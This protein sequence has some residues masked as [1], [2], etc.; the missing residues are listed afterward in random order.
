MKNER[1]ILLLVAGVQFVNVLDFMMVMPLGP[2]F[3]RS[4]GI[5]VSH[6]GVIG[7]SYTAAAS[8]SGLVGALFLDRFDRRPALAVA[9]I[10]LAAGTIL[11]GLAHGIT[12]L[13]AARVVAGAFGGPATSLS[14]SIVA[15]VVPPERR[16]RALGTVMSAFSVASVL[17]V[18][19][20]LVLA[21]WGTWRTPFFVVSALGVIASI[22]AMWLMPPMHGHL[23]LDKSDPLHKFAL[24]GL[25]RTNVFLALSMGAFVMMSM[26]VLVPNIS[27][28]VLQNLHYPRA[29]LPMLYAVGGAASFGTMRI[30]GRLTDRIGA[31][32]VGVAGSLATML[33]M[34]IGFHSNE[35]LVPIL[36]I[37]PMFMVSSSFR[38]VAYNT[39]TSKVPTA[40]ERAGYG[41]IQS[42][43]QHAFCACGAFLSSKLLS[44][45]PQGE[46]IGMP[47]L[48][49][50]SIGLGL[51]FPVL[52]FAL[53]RRL[54]DAAN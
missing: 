54:R 53:N 13:I 4:L 1:S 50:V 49:K 28:F 48:V 7:G 35:P 45:S 9:M 29:K 15:D 6:L 12:G 36:A 2:D 30:A 8:V 51:F 22:L 31:T 37:F 44:E 39:T 3:S 52:L 16:G 25:L 38:N 32:W 26:F 41:S 40:R 20:G 23:D 24:R 46:L 11:G 33:V 17:G 14:L 19:A 42:S 34:Y 18:P 5:D 10:G 47:T 43:V 27:T 21:Q